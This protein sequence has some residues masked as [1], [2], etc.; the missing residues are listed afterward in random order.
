MA[1]YCGFCG[2]RLDDD[3]R[4]CGQCGTSVPRMGKSTF[5][6]IRPDT[7]RKAKKGIKIAAILAGI[8]I[9]VAV[10]ACIVFNRIG[11]R[12]L[13][14]KTM[15]AYKEYDINTIIQNSS[16]I[17]YYN[18][19]ENY[20]EL[21]FKSAIG[22]SLD[23]YESSVGHNCKYS[24]D[25]VEIFTLSERKYDT[26]LADIEYMYPDFDTDM[27]EEIVIANL[28]VT[29]KQGKNTADGELCIT[30]SKELGEWKILYI[31]NYYVY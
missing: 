21:Y 8:V 24:Y 19:E 23:Y 30:M 16:D 14:Y 2:E 20:A 22:E 25:I 5:S 26:V 4:V 17:Y 15:T 7:K 28:L 18:N 12:G 10:I 11:S 3:D 6:G 9:I 1:K 29:A 13:V 27:I 31:D